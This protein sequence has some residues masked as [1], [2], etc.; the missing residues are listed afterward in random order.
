MINFYTV[1]FFAFLSWVITTL[2]DIEKSYHLT[3]EQKLSFEDTFFTLAIYYASILSAEAAVYYVAT[4]YIPEQIIITIFIFINLLSAFFF[5]SGK[6]EDPKKILA[7]QNSNF[8]NLAI[9]KVAKFGKLIKSETNTDHNYYLFEPIHKKSDLTIDKIQIKNVFRAEARNIFSPELKKDAQ[10][11]IV[12]RE[13][14][15]YY[16]TAGSAYGLDQI[17][18]DERILKKIKEG[19]IK[20]FMLEKFIFE[21]FQKLIEKKIPIRISQLLQ[22]AADEPYLSNYIYFLMCLESKKFVSNAVLYAILF[23]KKDLL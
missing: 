14:I 4:D 23:I 11:H 10:D 8:P 7:T 6:R 20:R 21:Q 18:Y 13:L 9:Q 1:V 3:Q 2:L 19:K 5:P 22:H 15:N 17:D 12:Y 16:N